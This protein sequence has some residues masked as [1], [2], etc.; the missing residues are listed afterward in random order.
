MTGARLDPSGPFLRHPLQPHQLHDRVTRTEDTI[1]LWHLGLPRLDPDSWSVAIDGLVR[2]PRRLT[3][4]ELKRRPRV[5]ITSVH[6]CCG[7]PLRPDEPARRVCNV[8]WGGVR[9][10]DLIAECQPQPEAR[11]LW[12]SGADHGVFQGVDCDA[13]VKDVPLERVAADVLI[14][15]EMNGA[16][17]RPENGHPARLVVPGFYGTNSVKWLQ[18]L[19]LAA[20]R[21]SGPFTTRWYSDAVRDA[22]G[23]PTDATAPVWSIAPESVIVSPAPDQVLKAGEDVEVWGWTWADGGVA[24][25]ELGADDGSHWMRATVEPPAGRA[26]QH[27]SATWRPQRRG[28][29]EL[30]SRAHSGDGR[31]Q[32]PSGARNA[33]H[34]VAIEVA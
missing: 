19:T 26:W 23:H 9:L 6:E 24:T 20:G 33:I 2:R 22:A 30:R 17:L 28:R 15:D 25:V 14:A 18:R 11:F 3:L 5:E 27:F 8:A 29:Q 21:A 12:A 16:P 13:Y 1:V 31:S 10:A 4:A 7:S 32:P 34:A